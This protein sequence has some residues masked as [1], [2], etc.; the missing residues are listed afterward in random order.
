MTTTLTKSQHDIIRL[1]VLGGV[2]AIG[3]HSTQSVNI[4]I[5]KGYLDRFGPTE[6]AKT[7]VDETEKAKFAT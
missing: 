6:K 7:Y 3:T 2:D 5:H 1:W 4:L